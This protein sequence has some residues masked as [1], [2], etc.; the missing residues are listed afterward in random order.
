MNFLKSRNFALF[1]IGTLVSKIGDKL[2]LLA[3]PWLIYELTG[4]S[5]YMGVMFFLETIPFLFISPIAGLL[6]DRFSHKLLLFTAALSQGLCLLAIVVFHLSRYDSIIPIFIF[7]FLIACG[8][9]I[10][11]VVLNSIIPSMFSKDRIVNVNSSFQFIDSTSL[12]FGSALAGILIS[13]VGAPL[14]LL[15]DAVSFLLIA[16]IVLFYKVSK[17]NK[18]KVTKGQSFNHLLQGAKYV[19]KH[20]TLGPLITIMMLVNISN[21]VIVAMLVFYSRDVLG[22]SAEQLGLIYT[23]TAVFQI[24]LTLLIP[25]I[26]RRFKH[27]N[28]MLLICLFISCI[29]IG[30]VALSVE[31]ITLSIAMVVHTA[32]IIIFNVMNKTLRMQIAPENLLG[33]VNGLFLMLSKSTLPLAGLLGGILAE[34][35]DLKIIFGVLSILTL[36]IITRYWFHPF[37]NQENYSQEKAM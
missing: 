26:I 22:I 1:F 9:A 21:A 31:W 34:F 15:I 17:S 8:G 28:R 13:L 37:N 24:L 11:S 5:F 25:S 23:I 14:V 20:N 12:L 29:G 32:P 2:Y 7:G 16:V 3:M 19:F 33:R 36:L 4:S 18:L 10:F 35:F 30:M 6:A 27:I